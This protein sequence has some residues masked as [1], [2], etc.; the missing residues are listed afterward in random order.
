MEMA[1]VLYSYECNKSDGF[2]MD[3]NAHQ[4]FGYVTSL[5]GLGLMSPFARDLQV[6]V[7][8][9]AGATPAY[10]GLQYQKSAPLSAVKGG[11]QGSSVGSAS[12]VGVMDQFS[13][14]GGVGDAITLNFYV[15]QEN[16]KQLKTLQQSTLKTSIIN[17]LGWWIADYDQET[18]L[19]FEQA[20]PQGTSITGILGKTNASLNV[21]LAPVVAK[22]G[23]NVNVYKVTMS[24]VPAANKTYPLQFAN[25]STAKVMKSWGLVV[26]TLASA[27]RP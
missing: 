17:A 19:W 15:S 14:G 11:S 1:S 18:K 12:V 26:G 5:A 25:S 8:F 20:Y 3:P 9:N 10:A 21:D 16:A 13:W 6:A 24:V 27:A 4:R 2:V 22:T 7:P 23:I